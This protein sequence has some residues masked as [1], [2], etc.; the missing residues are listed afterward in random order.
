VKSKIH[1]GMDMVHNLYLRILLA[2]LNIH[3]NIVHLSH[4]KSS[5][6]NVPAKKPC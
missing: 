2:V 5:E 3:I 1:V 4:S 6:N